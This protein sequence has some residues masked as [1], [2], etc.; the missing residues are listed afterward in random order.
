VNAFS[1]AIPLLSFN[2]GL[3]TGTGVIIAARLT[4]EKA[5]TPQEGILQLRTHAQLV[6][7]GDGF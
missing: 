2:L 3:G 1:R 6:Q 7:E 4:I 5:G